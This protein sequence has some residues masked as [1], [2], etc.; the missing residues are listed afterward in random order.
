MTVIGDHAFYKCEKLK[1]IH[2]PK[3]LEEIEDFAFSCCT[4]L[5]GG[6]DIPSSTKRVGKRS[7]EQCSGMKGVLRIGAEIIDENAFWG[8][9]GFSSLVILPSV[10]TIKGAAFYHCYGF[11]GDL[12][13]PEGVEEIGALSFAYCYGFDGTIY[14]PNSLTK[15]SQN[16]FQ[17]CI[18]IKG[19]LIVPE[20]ITTVYDIPE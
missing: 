16:A 1:E 20:G 10:K 4:S 12:I 2:L 11:E 14:L 13:F 17:D 15:L 7:F 6:L 18:K 5:S 8:C 9:Y 19:D 3:A